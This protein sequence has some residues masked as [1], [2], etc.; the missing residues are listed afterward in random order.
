MQYMGLGQQGH[1]RAESS[2]MCFVPPRVALRASTCNVLAL[3]VERAAEAVSCK[4]LR[5]VQPAQ[6]QGCKQARVP[7]CNPRQSRARPQ[8]LLGSGTANVKPSSTS[9]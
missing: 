4:S 6:L 5:D 1:I 3:S 8:C 2:V 7:F 9:P